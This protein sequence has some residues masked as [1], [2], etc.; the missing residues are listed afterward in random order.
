MKRL[1]LILAMVATVEF[2]GPV[3]ANHE[4]FQATLHEPGVHG[5][6]TVTLN[7]SHTQGEIDERRART[8]GVGARLSSVLP[9]GWSGSVR[10]VAHV[11]VDGEAAVDVEVGAGHVP[12]RGGGEEDHGVRDLS[13]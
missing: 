7:Y 6:I 12:G 10:L 13:G 11:A 4:I 1:G 8:P 5:T 9:N 3:S 2:A